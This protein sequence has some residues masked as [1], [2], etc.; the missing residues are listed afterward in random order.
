MTKTWLLKAKLFLLTNMYDSLSE[1]DISGTAWQK[2]Y[3]PTEIDK[4][5]SLSARNGEIRKKLSDSIRNTINDLVNNGI[6]MKD[7]LKNPTVREVLYDEWNFNDCLDEEQVI[8]S[9]NR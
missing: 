5:Y 8:K 7:L 3:S 9:I 2:Y 6:T 1:Y 4:I